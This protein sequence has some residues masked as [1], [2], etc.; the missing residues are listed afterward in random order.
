MDFHE[1]FGIGDVY[2]NL[3]RKPKFD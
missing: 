3:P 2:K 1:I